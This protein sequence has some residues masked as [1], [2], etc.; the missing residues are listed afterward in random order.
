MEFTILIGILASVFIGLIFLPK[1]IKKCN[2]VGLLW[3]DMNKFNNPK[4]VA[5]S[6]GIVVVMAF[7]FGVL[8]YVAI[9]TFVFQN[10]ED[11]NLRIFSLLSVVLILAIVGLVDD[12]LGWKHGGLS[13]RFRIF[14]AF[15]A[16]IPLI[17][18]NAGY[19]TIA[20]PY[21]GIMEL[22]VLYTF[23]AIPLGIAGAATT[24]NLL[25]GFNGLESGQGIILLSFLSFVAYKTGSSWLAVI[26]LIMVASLFIFYLYNK[27]PA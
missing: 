8:I 25:A 21:L 13:A 3:E 15:V 23:V 2:E 26:G 18:I 17:V 7:V 14:L 6:G 11:I 5:A 27:Y 19:H 16:A 9:R 10:S 20:L 22:G 1:W 12:L 24:Y 4:N